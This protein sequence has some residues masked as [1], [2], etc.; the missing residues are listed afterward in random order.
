MATQ[1]KAAE[2]ASKK[3]GTIDQ[4]SP[5]SN[6][7]VLA[8][9]GLAGSG[10]SA[11]ARQM[12]TL[13]SAKGY[14]VH[15]VKMSAII[16]EKTQK[17][18]PEIVSGVQKGQS[19][20]ER[21][22]AMQNS[23]DDIRHQHGNFALSS[24]AIQ[25]ISEM[26]GEAQPG[27]EK[28]AFIVD[29]LKHPQE[30][31]LFRRVY[32]SSFKL[33]AV[34]CNKENRDTRLFGEMTGSAKFSGSD[35]AQFEKFIA[36]DEDDSGNAHGQHVKDVFHQADFFLDN[37]VPSPLAGATANPELDRFFD[38]VLNNKIYRP[39]IGE[40]AIYHAFGA[41]LQSSCL[42]RQVGA[43]LVSQSGEVIALGTNDP[44][45]FGG[46]IYNE[47]SSPDARCHKFEFSMEDGAV[48]VGCH[49]DRK[50]TELIKSISEWAKEKL[51]PAITENMK[52]PEGDDNRRNKAKKLLIE[53]MDGLESVFD[54]LPGIRSLI[55]FS[56]S[57][58]AEMDAI[59]SA[60]REGRSTVGCDLYVTTYPCHSCARHLVAA[61]IRNVYFVEPYTKSL[62]ME[63]HKD[64]V[65]DSLPS[66]KASDIHQMTVVPFTGVG[67]SMFRDSFLKKGDLKHGG[68]VLNVPDQGLP[69]SAVRLS[70]LKVVETRAIEL[71]SAGKAPA[72]D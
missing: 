51:I 33:M 16:A 63:L 9:S 48:F 55:E 35:K 26:R 22:I 69:D 21:A 40:K 38:L 3:V 34:H 24:F 42:S 13:L 30:V 62:A 11:I 4:V 32:D 25:K 5:K 56:R 67:P 28:I 72:N 68:G 27:K 65:I 12:E 2:V 49:N 64:A 8:L 71:A 18:L 1:L 29:S 52:I 59:L 19:V 61:G 54:T 44:P 10:C 37:S 6:E 60:A 14:V 58:H 31:D 7:L 66:G 46:G 53:T 20:L 23:G 41:A 57:I 43:C 47:N 50:K 17:P 15:I 45:K 39:T 36:R 70:D